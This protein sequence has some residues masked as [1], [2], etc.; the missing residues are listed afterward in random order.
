MDPA[1]NDSKPE[2]TSQRNLIKNNQHNYIAVSQ[3]PLNLN[4]KPK[5]SQ[6]NSVELLMTII[7][8]RKLTCFATLQLWNLNI[9]TVFTRQVILTLEFSSKQTTTYIK[10]INQLYQKRCYT[11]STTLSIFII[12][13]I[14]A[15]YQFNFEFPVVLLSNSFSSYQSSNSGVVSC[16]PQFY[17]SLYT[18]CFCLSSSSFAL[19]SILS[20][21]AILAIS[22]SLLDLFYLGSVA[23]L[24]H[25]SSFSSSQLGLS[26]L[27]AFM[28]TT[29]ISKGF[30]F[31]F[32]RNCLLELVCYNL[33]ETQYFLVP[34]FQKLATFAP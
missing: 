10:Y 26:L 11:I 29:T 27:D 7:K 28:S 8:C 21:F 25:Q 13:H 6:I 18:C 2:M 20:F 32:G 9:V 5:F 17:S 16:V 34:L 19:Y 24:H 15:L 31:L 23:G 14:L 4:K 1:Y 12:C 3:S 22:I 30:I 33:P